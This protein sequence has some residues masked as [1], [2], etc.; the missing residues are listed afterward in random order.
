M[1]VQLTCKK[2]IEVKGKM[3]TYNPGDWVDVG[4]QTAL[5]WISEGSAWIPEG[6]AVN[7]MSVDCGVFLWGDKDTG[8]ERLGDYA[9]KIDVESGDWPA[10]PWVKTMIYNPGLQLRRDLVP[11]GFSLLDTWQ[12]AVPIWDYDKLALDL[13]D[14]AERDR[15]VGIIRDLRVPAYAT[16]LMFVKRSDD[17]QRLMDVW[18]DEHWQGN[19]PRLSFLRALYQVR[20]VILALPTT[21]IWKDMQLD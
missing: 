7:L 2:N 14:Q 1:W 15:T 19:D 6:K 21:W 20:P 17:T 3:R 18:R 12:A 8:V 9:G 13:G 10:L 11:I 16:D 5:Y 4:K